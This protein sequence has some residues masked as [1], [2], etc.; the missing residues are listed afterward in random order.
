MESVMWTVESGS[1]HARRAWSAGPDAVTDTAR[2]AVTTRL[3]A[4]AEDHDRLA[5]IVE[6]PCTAAARSPPRERNS[7]CRKGSHP[8]RSDRNFGALEN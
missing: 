4:S 7:S 1:N 6:G 8:L 2:S 3:T 5:L